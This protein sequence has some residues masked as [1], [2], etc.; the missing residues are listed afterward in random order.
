MDPTAIRTFN[1][2]VGDYLLGE[3]IF[4]V[5]PLLVEQVNAREARVPASYGGYVQRLAVAVAAEN[6][7]QTTWEA[8]ETRTGLSPQEEGRCSDLVVA[9]V[10]KMMATKAIYDE[11][12]Q[13]EELR[14]FLTSESAIGSAA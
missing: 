13:D 1:Q 6:I 11:A 10:E 4:L 8:L 14:L 9:R 7:A 5:L 12:Q 3:G 2:N